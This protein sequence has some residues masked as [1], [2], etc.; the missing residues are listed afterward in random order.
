MSNELAAITVAAK[1]H[2]FY[3]SMSTNISCIPLS[4]EDEGL[5]LFDLKVLELSF[6]ELEP[7]FENEVMI[8]K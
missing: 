6:I 4:L 7:W 1:A 3:L 8:S 5:K 2:Y